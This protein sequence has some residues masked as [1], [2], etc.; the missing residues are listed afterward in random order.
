MKPIECNCEHNKPVLKK[1]NRECCKDRKEPE[2]KL[3]T[4]SVVDA[5]RAS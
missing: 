2:P 3:P 4:L 1:M 5:G